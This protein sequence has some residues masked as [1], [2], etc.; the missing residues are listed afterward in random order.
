[1]LI[2]SW[3]AAQANATV[4]GSAIV[5]AIVAVLI[6]LVAHEAGHVVAAR[7]LRGRLIPAVWGPGALVA[8]LFLPFHAATGPFF[9]ERFRQRDGGARGTWRFHIAGPL[10]NALVGLVAFLAFLAVP[11]PAFRLIAQVQLAAI[12]YTLLPIRPLDGW[13]LRRERP[14]VLLALG[15]AVVAA[16]AAFSLGLL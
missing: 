2:T 4:A 13:A 9:A 5:L 3:Q 15:F 14:R 16:A 10:A 8:L 1:M 11:A 7:L 12:A 6:A